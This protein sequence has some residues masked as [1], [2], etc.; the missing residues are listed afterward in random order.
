M[1]PAQAIADLAEISSQI[2]S[3]VLLGGDG[4]LVATSV[5]DGDRAAALAATAQAIVAR[6]ASAAGEREAS[7]IELSLLEGSV[8]VVRAG[9]RTILATTRPD[10][11]VGLVLYDLRSCLRNA[12]GEPPKPARRPRKKTAGG[13]DAA[14]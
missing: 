5:A 3:V 9:E 7:Q 10:P 1:E 6:A 12:A 13:D 2:E 11:T 4:A 14:A 8:F